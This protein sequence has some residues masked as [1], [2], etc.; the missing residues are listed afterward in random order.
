[1]LYTYSDCIKKLNPFHLKKITEYNEIVLIPFSS[2]NAR[3]VLIEKMS[4][5]GFIEDSF[6][7]LDPAHKNVL[8][9]ISLFFQYLP[10]EYIHKISEKLLVGE[11]NLAGITASLLSMGLIYC[12]ENFKDNKTYYL[13]PAEF[14]DPC[15][16]M[17]REQISSLVDYY[18]G[19]IVQ[20][21]VAVN[22]V[23][24]SIL[25]FL[26]IGLKKEIKLNIGNKLNKRTLNKIESLLNLS[27]E[28]I[29]EATIDEYVHDV[30]AYTKNAGFFKSEDQIDL[31]LIEQWVKLADS[32]R[33]RFLFTGLVFRRRCKSSLAQFAKLLSALPYGQLFDIKSLY[34]LCNL[35]TDV[36][37]D[38]VESFAKMPL[39][40]Y[41]VLLFYHLGIIEL[42]SND[43]HCY[44]AWKI[45]EYGAGL[46]ENDVAEQ[47]NYQHVDNII[48]QPNFDVLIS[49]TADFELL[50]KIYR[51]ADLVQCD[52]MLRFQ[53]TKESIYRG[54]STG[55]DKDSIIPLFEKNCT[56]SISQNVMYS[57]KEWCDDYGAVY[58]MD[59]FLLRCKNK[60]IAD[61]LKIHPKTKDY[62]KGKFSDTDLFVCKDDYEVL[63]EELRIQ[64]FMP[65]ENIIVPDEERPVVKKVS[66]LSAIS[67]KAMFDI[68]KPLHFEL[69]KIKF[70][71]EPSM[72]Q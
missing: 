5:P 37:S 51:I 55:I 22:S 43:I 72:V 60:Y 8:M 10:V 53:I 30:F 17:A 52:Q 1:M 31:S 69:D 46:I 15:A 41:P 40:C 20:K 49:R 58:F 9:V 34:L 16:E 56:E 68:V 70:I 61:Q 35:V 63:M 3:K 71:P 44:C 64:G 13:V 2:N 66:F 59:I 36:E 24:L 54:L 42:A 33:K 28:S 38:S 19:D 50:W 7:K 25:S 23:E 45:T 67:G 39:D 26:V 29:S 57:L 21:H 14:K 11:D 27:F 62:I 65:L 47:E 32:D 48:I 6:E 18:D 12:V 4:R